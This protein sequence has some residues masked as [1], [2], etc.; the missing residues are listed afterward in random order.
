MNLLNYTKK[1][2][3]KISYYDRLTREA[4]KNFSMSNPFA[5]PVDKMVI[6]VENCPEKKDDSDSKNFDSPA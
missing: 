6:W 1:L 5:K 4:K 3:E 2:S